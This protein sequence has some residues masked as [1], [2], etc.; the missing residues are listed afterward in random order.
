MDGAGPSQVAP[1][2]ELEGS[3][4]GDVLAAERIDGRWYV[5]GG[6]GPN[7]Y[8][9]SHIDVV[10]DPGGTDVYR[11]PRSERPR[12]QLVVD[13]DGDDRYLGENGAAGPASGLLGVSVV[14]DR[15]GND[16]YEGGDL[17][18]GAGLMGAGLILDLAGNDTYKGARWTQG[19]AK[20]G[21]GGIVD[22][23]SGA[24]TYLAH[25]FGQGV[26]GATGAVCLR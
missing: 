12:V 4:K 21:F 17:S 2:S 10:I 3:V 7:E 20:Y 5:Y 14:V 25:E 16:H 8:D 11:Y 26:G 6:Y 1:P 18:C 9:L 15:A 23:G 13:W 24:D 19:A 22:L